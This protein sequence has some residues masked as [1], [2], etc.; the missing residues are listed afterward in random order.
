MLKKIM[1]GRFGQAE[2]V[3]AVAS[4]LASSDASY[5]T[6]ADIRIDGDMTA[7]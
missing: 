6:A 4:F 3:V 7:W 1:L 2:E 5:I